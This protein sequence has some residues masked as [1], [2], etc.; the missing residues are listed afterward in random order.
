[1]V[2]FFWPGWLLMDRFAAWNSSLP[3]PGP[4]HSNMMRE[5]ADDTAPVPARVAGMPTKA[6]RVQRHTSRA[7]DSETFHKPADAEIE[8]RS[9]GGLVLPTERQNHDRTNS[10][11]SDTHPRLLR[12]PILELLWSLGLGCLELPTGVF[13]PLQVPP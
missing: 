1:M 8:S 9:C 4:W 11:H 5:F 13:K 7:G 12:F 2:C 10:L 6:Q 3:C